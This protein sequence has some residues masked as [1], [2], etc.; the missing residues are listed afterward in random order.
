MIMRLK[1]RLNLVICNRIWGFKAQAVYYRNIS[2]HWNL[3]KGLQATKIS[4]IIPDPVLQ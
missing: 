4:I 3:E 1:C 2:T